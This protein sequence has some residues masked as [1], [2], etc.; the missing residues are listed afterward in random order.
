MSI[1]KKAKI[2]PECDLQIAEHEFEWHLEHGHDESF[3]D[4]NEYSEGS[5]DVDFLQPNID[6]TRLYAHSYREH[7]HYGS[8]SGHD[9]F[10]D[11]SEA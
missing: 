3:E 2:C 6:A 11:E 10:D 4:E 5:S 7:G 1:N 8:H 9:G